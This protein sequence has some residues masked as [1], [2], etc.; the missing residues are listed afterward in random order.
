MLGALVAAGISYSI[1]SEDIDGA[2]A[3]LIGLAIGMFASRWYLRQPACLNRFV[4]TIEKRLDANAVG[5]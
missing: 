5:A 2:A 4:P 3:A 1:S